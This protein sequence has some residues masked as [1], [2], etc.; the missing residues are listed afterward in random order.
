MRLALILTLLPGAALADSL[1]AART[2]PARTVISEGDV[3]TV[4]AEIAGAATSPEAAVGLETRVAIYA[5]RP[6][7]TAD[8]GAP[9]LVERNAVVTLLYRAG[10]LSIRA[11]GRALARGGAGEEIRVM[12]LGSRT[13]VTGVIGPDGAVHVGDLP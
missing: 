4:D 2:L 10:G 12:N 3:M 1:I 13:T 8:L 5:G 11:E 7:R 9:A 6:V